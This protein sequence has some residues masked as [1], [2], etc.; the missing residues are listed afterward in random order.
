MMKT[1]SQSKNIPI[2]DPFQGAK[3]MQK[4]QLSNQAKRRVVVKEHH[5][6]V[7]ATKDLV[8]VKNKTTTTVVTHDVEIEI[9]RSPKNKSAFVEQREDEDS[10]QTKVCFLTK[11]RLLW[12]CFAKVSC[13]SLSPLDVAH[14]ISFR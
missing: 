7:E 6:E 4:L 12:T 5:F 2:G 11:N 1:R 14:R 13:F 8:K 9:R 10:S 3:D